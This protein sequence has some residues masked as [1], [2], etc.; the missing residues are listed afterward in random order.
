MKEIKQKMPRNFSIKVKMKTLWIS[1]DQEARSKS[2][3]LEK[4]KRELQR[5]PGHCTPVSKRI[6]IESLLIIGSNSMKEVSYHSNP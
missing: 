5:C 6:C 3:R 4:N 1:E 2:K